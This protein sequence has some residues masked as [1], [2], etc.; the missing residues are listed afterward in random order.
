MRTHRMLHCLLALCCCELLAGAGAA[1]AQDARDSVVP[2]TDPSRPAL[3]TVSVFRGD[4]VV[5]G[6]SRAD[7]LVRQPLRGN[8][9]PRRRQVDAP[10]GMRRLTP[11]SVL[12]I[13][14]RNN[15][16][17]IEAPCMGDQSTGPT[18]PPDPN[19][20]PNPRPSGLSVPPPL[21]EMPNLDDFPC[22]SLAETDLE[23]QVPVKTRLR[24]STVQGDVTVEAVDGVIEV[25]SLSGDIELL[26]VSGAMVANS[27]AGDVTAVL[28]RADANAPMA[29]TTL[30]GE[31]D[32][33]LPLATKA[34]V[35][36]RTLSGDMFT[37][38][39]IPPAASGAPVRG[40]RQ[41]DGRLRFDIERTAGGALNGG[42]PE[43]ELR[44]FTGE[45]YLRRGK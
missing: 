3:V 8:P 11:G 32:V 19:P 4:I 24:L 41:K 44:S 15:E 18:R 2:L 10:P 29:F 26:N 7:I 38:F 34:N 21:V 6:T 12:Q 43:I 17:T 1:H 5:R 37:D 33:T 9:N 35:K 22:A 30:N 25:N 27:V 42:G 23:I 39:D 45:I 14:E 13:E 40:T 31:V 16:V 28:M 36:L 20:N